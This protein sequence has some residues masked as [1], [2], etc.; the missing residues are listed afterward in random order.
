MGGGPEVGRPDVAQVGIGTL[1]VFVAMVLV[2]ALGAGVLLDTAGLLQS[3]AQDTG[4][5]STRQVS[6]SLQVV[7][8]VGNVSRASETVTVTVYNDTHLR[9]VGWDGTPSNPE[10]KES[11]LVEDGQ[12]VYL[13]TDSG[14]GT[15]FV[16]GD[17]SVRYTA[18]EMDAVSA[19]NRARV[20]FEVLD[21]GG[22]VRLTDALHGTQVGT[23]D[24]P[25]TMQSGSSPDIRFNTNFPPGVDAPMIGGSDYPAGS[26]YVLN[27]TEEREREGP[28][29]VVEEVSLT[30]TPGPGSSAIDLGDAT[31]HY[32][33]DREVARLSYTSGDATGETFEI[34]QLTGSGP[35]LDGTDRAII[36]I[37]TTALG[38]PNR[39]LRAGE[40]AQITVVT[41]SGAT[42]TVSISA[43]RTLS[44]DPTVDL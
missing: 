21:D 5:S 36:T 16:Y 30:V 18:S 11:I 42:R 6:T 31:I 43:P 20:R 14:S 33:S 1:V 10:P 26:S 34:R 32:T 40:S 12:T 3:Q 4:E 22:D 24:P 25:V 15:S 13:G 38:D 17:L 41:S 7:S 19:S 8:N 27:H 44:G 37:N 9:L 35:V 29:S 28:L 23:V 2:A 39:S